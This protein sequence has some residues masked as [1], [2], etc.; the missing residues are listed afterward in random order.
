MLSHA[1]FKKIKLHNG[2]MEH[3]EE[4]HPY[5]QGMM[6]HYKGGELFKKPN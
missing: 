2:N 5:P 6:I 3:C 1:M 4:P